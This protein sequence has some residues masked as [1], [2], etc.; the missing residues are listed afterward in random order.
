MSIGKKNQE[1]KNKSKD[2]NEPYRK[3]KIEFPTSWKKTEQYSNPCS[4]TVFKGSR[5]QQAYKT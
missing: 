1:K 3:T 5:N 4:L 2:K